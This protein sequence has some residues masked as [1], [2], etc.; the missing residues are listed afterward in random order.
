VKQAKIKAIKNEQF[1]ALLKTEE[2]IEKLMSYKSNQFD[3]NAHQSFELPLVHPGKR[4]RR[5][6]GSFWVGSGFISG[7]SNN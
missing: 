6:A 3:R 2:K 4:Q 5:R 1:D 7:I